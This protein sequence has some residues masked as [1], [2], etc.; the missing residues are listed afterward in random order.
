MIKNKTLLPWLFVTRLLLILSGFVA[1]SAG[2]EE[3]LINRRNLEGWKGDPRF[4]RVE[5]GKIIGETDN[6]DRKL[7]RNTF[8]IW[9]GGELTDFEIVMQVR[10]LGSNN[11]GFQYRSQIADPE[12]FAVQGYQ[13]DM[14]PN[15]PYNGMLYEEGGRGILCLRGQSVVIDSNGKRK[16]TD[17]KDGVPETDLAQWNEYRLVA[18]GPVVTHWLNGKLAARI[19]DHETGKFSR[20]GIIA[21]QLHAGEPMRAEF[22]DIVL[23]RL[24]PDEEAKPQKKAA[25]PPTQK[26]Q[27]QWIW[28][29]PK[30]G[31]GE[32]IFV[33]KSVTIP[34]GVT[35]A[36]L[37]VAADDEFTLYLDGREI[38][39]SKDWREAFEIDLTSEFKKPGE[40]VFAARALNVGGPAGFAFRLAL[41]GTD[42]EQIVVSNADWKWSKVSPEGWEKPGFS[43]VSWKSAVAVGSMGDGPWGD[44]FQASLQKTPQTPVDVTADFDVVSGF[45]LERIYQVP[46]KQGSW[47]AMTVDGK[48]RLITSDQNG[49]LYRLTPPSL[50]D[51][52]AVSEAQPIDIPLAGAQGLLWVNEALYVVVSSTDGGVYRVT[53]SNTDGVFDQVEKFK[54]L[55]GSGEHGPHGLA[56]SPNG[57]WIYLVAGNHTDIPEFD[58]TLVPPVWDED[59]LLPRRPDARGHARTRMAPGGWIARFTPDGEKWELVSNG[60]RNGYD[61]AF[62]QHG[63][64]F[65]YDSD[66][67]WDHGTP[68]YRPTRIS[69]VTS[70]SEFGW[71]H[72]T[73]KWPEYYE[74]SVPSVLDIGPGSPTGVISGLGLKFP[75]RYQQALFMMDWTFATIYAVHL[76]PSGA[77]YTAK[78]EEFIAGEGLPV[79]NGVVGPDGSL[80]FVTGGRGIDS[81]VFRVSYT[82]EES[83]E[84]APVSPIAPKPAKLAELRHSLEDLH[85][86]PDPKELDKIWKALSHED[87]FIRF[88]ARIALEHLSVDSWKN[89]L[90]GKNKPWASVLAAMALARTGSDEDQAIALGALDKLDA[91]SLDAP[92]LINLLRAYGLVFARHGTPEEAVRLALIPRFDDLLP[93][94]NEDV[95]RELCRMLV[96]LRSPDVVRKTLRLMATAPATPAPSW[97]D[98]AARNEIYGTPILEMIENMPPAQNLFYAYC[99]RAYEGDWTEGQYRQFFTWLSEA[100][101]K[102]GGASYKGFIEDFRKETLSRATPA[103]QEMVESWNLQEPAN[104]FANLPS[105]TGP[106]RAW[107]ADEAVAAVKKGLLGRNQLNGKKMFQATLC[108]ACHRFDGEGGGAGP[109]LTAVSGRFSI[110]DLVEAIIYPDKEVSDQYRFDQI[111]LTDGSTLTGKVLEEREQELVVAISPFDFSQ[112]REIPREKVTSVEP[113]P[114]SPM[115]A[116]LINRLNEEELRDLLAYLL[117]SSKSKT[118]DL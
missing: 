19:E 34:P 113:S 59:Q 94:K 55:N 101:L 39:S 92:R 28:S 84:P 29:Q 85:E 3:A 49:K 11:S 12:S 81:A 48:G 46:K 74:D 30:P 14:H 51:P 102:S 20:S 103:E 91:A 79:T 50:T 68:W 24:I 16:T 47:V 114:T 75:A 23:T 13:M 82:G 86:N 31:A 71:R 37:L 15:Q 76:T 72:G 27:A 63:E 104:P 25:T 56:L 78:T 53:D 17:L 7:A 118:D 52:E 97:A 10:I 69:H 83:V 64:L 61:L 109:D 115:P 99:L 43:T 35:Q 44:V 93:A 58:S 40:R 116:G 21:L 96:Y 90:E 62:D 88:A 106:G 77:T 95:N 107:Q 60:Y 41:T 45:K 98:L 54:S 36:S 105:P 100:A 73:G 1:L 9:E 57:E 80:Y 112:T 33:R 38:G 65:T 108:A 66:M 42:Q 4:W 70:G 26:K 89:R 2:A 32:E 5:D 22:K 8:L 6:A 117:K 110:R 111:T 87:R 18:K 67:E